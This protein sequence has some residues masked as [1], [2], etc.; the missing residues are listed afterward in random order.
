MA[1]IGHLINNVRINNNWE[2]TAKNGPVMWV[3]W[4]T[5]GLG[6]RSLAHI[7]PE[8]RTPKA[9]IAESN[10]AE[11]RPTHSLLDCTEGEV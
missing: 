8:R 1:R 7:W 9:M 4:G 2:Q 5:Q 10:R 6:I 11:W 3:M